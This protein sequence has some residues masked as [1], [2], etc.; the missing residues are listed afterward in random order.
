MLAALENIKMLNV[1]PL[2]HDMLFTLVLFSFI[3]QF[4][5]KTEFGCFIISF[6]VIRKMVQNF[7]TVL[8]TL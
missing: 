3:S 7:V 8:G 4:W 1:I 6:L 5:K 2:P